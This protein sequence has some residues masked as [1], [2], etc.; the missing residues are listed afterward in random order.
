MVRLRL[1][2][3]KT[4]YWK[5]LKLFILNNKLLF[6][7][8]VLA[9]TIGFTFTILISSLTKA[10][11]DTKQ[12]STLDNY[13]R[14][15][16]VVSDV[17]GN[18]V[19][20]IKEKIPEFNYQQYQIL[21]TLGYLDTDI[22][23]GCMDQDLGEYLGFELI[24][25]NWPS[26]AEQIV[27]EE[28]LAIKMEVDIDK[29]PYSIELTKNNQINN[30]QITGIISNYSSNLSVDS[31]STLNTAIYPS[32]LCGE[33]MSDS[34]NV[35]LI[36]SQKKI[37]FKSSDEDIFRFLAK[38]DPMELESK[39][40]TLNEKLYSKGYNESKDIIESSILHTILL[41]S[42]LILS[43]IVIL[44]VILLKNKQ[45]F[46]LL[47]ALGLSSRKKNITLILI[48]T[49]FLTLV[50]LLCYLLMIII[51]ILYINHEFPE[52]IRSYQVEMQKCF[53][54]QLFIVLALLIST[55]IA[56]LQRKHLEI[57]DGL[58]I[59]KNNFKY[60]FKKVNVWMIFMNTILLFFIISSMNFMT[61]FKIQDDNINYKLYSK[62]SYSY[63]IINQ[64]S[65][66][67][68]K[69]QFFPFSILDSFGKFRD[70]LE[71]SMEADT[72][73]YSI[74]LEKNNVDSY[75]EKL[76]TEY[77]T[78]DAIAYG[79]RLREQLPAQ[80]NDY[81]SVPYNLI[82][83]TILPQSE[84]NEFMKNNSIPLS[85]SGA[86]KDKSCIM[87][88]P[89]YKNNNAT[90]K[91]NGY[92]YIGG[93]RD[94]NEEVKFQKEKFKVEQLITPE[95]TNGFSPITLVISEDTARKS[96]TILGYNS[97]TFTVKKDV[98]A[99]L[100]HEIDNN[101]YLLLASIQGGQLE[102]TLQK[103]M[104]AKLLENYTNLLSITIVIFCVLSII[105]YIVLSSYIDWEKHKHEY[106]IL[107]SFGM[108]YHTLQHKI[109][110]QYSTSII[111]ASVIAIKLGS[112]AF[113]NGALTN[114]QI[115]TSVI[116]TLSITYLCRLLLYVMF[117]KQSICSMLNE[118]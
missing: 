78:E 110:I 107:R 79:S 59:E 50:L 96:D 23:F 4:N 68:Y 67:R 89:N 7:L 40:V 33:L 17:N 62:K 115:L 39:H 90:I 118:A 92:F 47:E 81:I 91:E 6:F 63:E 31:A 30:Y 105:I 45:V 71:I 38:Y 103:L 55:S 64:Y 54:R 111:I 83:I 116:L 5:I 93:I 102:S 11:L 65:V 52:Y 113:P 100:L 69:E 74:L 112:I 15:I 49:L 42:I 77:K 114:I 1:K 70:Y 19:K 51:G 44:R 26:T 97:I 29:L 66:A 25:G 109:F 35:S 21:G 16:S 28:Y 85:L 72:Q 10:I 58:N 34:S 9:L 84:Y 24:K 46:Y 60:K 22:T 104:N 20:K 12:K 99:D 98:P 8:S 101:I 36:V 32:I 82:K 56:I 87:I 95:I 86:N 117:R 18:D 75:F 73:L 37:N 88:I 94:S 61:M 43:A 3:D 106:G 41:H 48:A 13:G 108:S 80:S 2:K 76:L 57:I 53:L 27:M 14:F